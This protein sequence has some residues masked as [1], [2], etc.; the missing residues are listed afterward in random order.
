MEKKIEEARAEFNSILDFV[1]RAA[2]GREIH[3]VE[4]DL[5]RRVLRLGRILLELYVL[6]CGTGKTGEAL[7]REDGAVFR[8]LRESGR[9]YL[10]I[11]GEITIMRA[12]YAKDGEKGFFP[13]DA[14]L[15]LPHRKYSYALQDRM[16]YGAVKESYE[17]TAASLQKDLYLKVAH[18]PIQEVTRDCTAAVEEFMDSLPP[19]PAQLEGPIRVHTVDCKGIRMRPSERNAR[20]VKTEEKPGR[21]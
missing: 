9:S 6:A 18:R 1:V 3:E 19:P 4:E 11:F 13:L 17:A 16:T 7:I 10:S 2:L 21:N 8:Y 12:Y 5:Y 14:R 15:N 20:Q